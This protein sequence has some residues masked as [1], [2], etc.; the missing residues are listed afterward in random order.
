M[1]RISS[2][3]LILS[4]YYIISIIG[5]NVIVLAKPSLWSSN[6]EIIIRYKRYFNDAKLMSNK[7]VSEI[8]IDNK[9]AIMLVFTIETI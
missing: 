8:N 3:N 5:E 9:K 4:I 2:G 6:L 7:E 1:H